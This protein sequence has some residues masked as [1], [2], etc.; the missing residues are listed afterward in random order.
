ML[1]R[2]GATLIRHADD[3]L[4]AV[5]PLAGRRRD[6]TAIEE[7]PPIPHEDAAMVDDEARRRVLEALGPTPTP[8]DEIVR[9]V[10]LTASQVLVVLLELELAGR[11]ERHGGGRVSLLY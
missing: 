7:P 2:E 5:L 1:L 8:I 3:V 4:E 6:P 11:T 10:G 9:H